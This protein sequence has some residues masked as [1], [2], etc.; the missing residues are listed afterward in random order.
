MQC[1]GLGHRDS[2]RAARRLWRRA[3]ALGRVRP[4]LSPPPL[5]PGCGGSRASLL[6]AALRMRGLLVVRCKCEPKRRARR[7]TGRTAAL[8]ALWATLPPPAPAPPGAGTAAAGVLALL[9]TAEGAVSWLPRLSNAAVA[10]SPGR[11][12]EAGTAYAEVPGRGVTAA[13]AASTTPRRDMSAAS[14]PSCTPAISSTRASSS[15]TRAASFATLSCPAPSPAPLPLEG[16]SPPYAVGAGGAGAS[17]SSAPTRA[18]KAATSA[19][20]AGAPCS[21]LATG[22]V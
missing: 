18:A 19:F 21:T 1:R 15:P 17:A 13:R 22:R 5:R 8:A 7:R 11:V 12:E 9:R 10:A 20:S 3:A 16:S 4:L 6:P 14:A 2:A